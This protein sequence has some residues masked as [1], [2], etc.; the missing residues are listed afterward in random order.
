MIE[1]VMFWNEPNNKHHWDFSLDPDWSQFAKMV[2]LAAAAV[3]DEAPTLTRVMGGISPI[4]PRFVENLANKGALELIDVVALHGFPLDWNDWQ[5]TDWPARL[6]DVRGVT[7]RQIWVTEVGASSFGADEIQE[8]GLKRTAELLIKEN[9]PRI[10]WYSLYDLPRAWEATSTGDSPGSGD[11]LRHYHMGLL[12]A[13]GTPK[14]A[15]RTFQEF[16][17]AL[18]IC[19]WFHFEDHR[20]NDAVKWMQSLGVR[21]VRIGLSWSESYKPN[22]LGWFDRL[23]KAL[24]NFVVT[25]TFC[26]TPWQLGIMPDHTSPPKDIE[27]YAEFCSSMLRR[28]K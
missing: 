5:L 10:H 3:A 26:Y 27:R 25:V 24:E 8:F 11:Y 2:R 4:D 21:H 22:A 1:A 20:L 6:D 16:T 9:I 15:I 28:Y 19:Q 7:N 14:P 12:R 13:D 17:P 18:G 23:M